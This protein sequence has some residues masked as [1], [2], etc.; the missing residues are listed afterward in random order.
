[1]DVSEILTEWMLL[2]LVSKLEKELDSGRRELGNT[3]HL[4]NDI[5]GAIV[6]EGEQRCAIRYL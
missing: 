1:M 6:I 2:E 5:T 3:H 4:M